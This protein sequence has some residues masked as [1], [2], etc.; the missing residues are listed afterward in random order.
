MLSWGGATVTLP[1]MS[2]RSTTGLLTRWT[3]LPAPRLEE[4][5]SL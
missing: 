4:D 3:G 5:S 2:G 1:Y